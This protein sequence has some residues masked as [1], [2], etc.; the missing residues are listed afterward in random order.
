MSQR[1]PAH[2]ATNAGSEGRNEDDTADGDPFVIPTQEESILRCLPAILG[3]KLC[4]D[5][6]KQKNS[7]PL[8]CS[9]AFWH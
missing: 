4:L 6:T 7:L 2:N 8:R 9:K 5:M 1:L 3:D